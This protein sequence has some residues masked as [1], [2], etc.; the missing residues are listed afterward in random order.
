MVVVHQIY[1]TDLNRHRQGSAILILRF[2]YHNNQERPW[3]NG[4]I[5]V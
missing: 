4:L 1:P 2:N 5:K 3:F